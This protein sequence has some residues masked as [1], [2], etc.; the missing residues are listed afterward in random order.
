MNTFPNESSI[1]TDIDR[2]CM[3]AYKSIS[4]TSKGDSLYVSPCCSIQPGMITT[5]DI[6]FENHELLTQIRTSWQNGEIHNECQRCTQLEDRGLPSVRQTIN[7]SIQEYYTEGRANRPTTRDEIFKTEILRMDYWVGDMCNLACVTCGPDNSSMWRQ[8]LGYPKAK[9][10]IS[11]NNFWNKIDFSKIAD[12]HI[13]G[14]EPFLSR[15]HVEFIQ[16]IPDKHRINLVYNT[17]GT[18]RP[19][20]EVF[21]VW[22][23][24]RH[25]E[26]MFSFDDLGDRFEYLRWPAKWDQSLETFEFILSNMSPN[27]RIGLFV[28]ESILNAP[29]MDEIRAWWQQNYPVDKHDRPIQFNSVIAGG[30]WGSSDFAGEYSLKTLALRN[31][32][33]GKNWRDLFSKSVSTVEQH[34]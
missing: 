8:I 12:I 27:S 1:Q 2:T 17:N 25:I 3:A 24:F 34:L 13:H 28:V 9:Q 33:Y 15:D 29:Y 6:D 7:Q 26:L 4:I 23:E 32:Q 10:K 31:Q 20:P 22:R 30:Y 14:G 11:A 21:E 5:G 19:G 16:A 18:V